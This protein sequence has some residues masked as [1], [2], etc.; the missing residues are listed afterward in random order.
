ML[1]TAMGPS[2]RR[3]GVRG[4]C[5]C[6]PSSFV[7]KKSEML[8]GRGLPPRTG[9]TLASLGGRRPRTGTPSFKMGLSP[10]DMAASLSAR[11]AVMR[12]R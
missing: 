9:R 1:E 7:C 2:R 10:V 11:Q 6:T 4:L 8:R 3:Q 12:G 5:A